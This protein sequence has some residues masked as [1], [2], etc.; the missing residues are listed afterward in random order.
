MN[1]V[2][3]IVYM[4]A[5]LKLIY[6]YNQTVCLQFSISFFEECVKIIL[7]VKNTGH[8]FKLFQKVGQ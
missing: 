5:L 4:L 2:F 8:V 3:L 6:I 7:L 1:Y